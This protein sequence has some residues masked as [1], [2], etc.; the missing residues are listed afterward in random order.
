[1]SEVFFDGEFLNVRLSSRRNYKVVLELAKTS[2]YSEYIQNEGIYVISATRKNARELFNANYSFDKSAEIFIKDLKKINDIKYN[3]QLMFKRELEKNQT[4]KDEL[5]DKLFHFQQEGVS[6]MLEMNSNILLADE[7]GLGK[8]PQASSYLRLKE[9]SL[10][11]LVICPA[12][13]K[14]NWERELEKWANVKSYIINGKTPE[15]L[16]EEF[17]RKYPVFII[18]YDILGSEDKA[19]KTAEENRKKAAKEA[20]EKYRK[21]MLKVHGWCDKLIEYNFKTIIADESQALGE[22]GT[23]RTRAVTQICEALPDAK[24]IMISGT[25]YETRTSQFYPLLHIIRPTE[26]NNKFKFLMRYCDPVKTFFGWQFNGLSNAEELHERICKF[27]IR[28]LKKDVLKDLPPKIRSVIPL[29]ISAS[30]RAMYDKADSELELAVMN[31]E[32]CVLAKMAK[33]KQVAFEAKKNAAIQ[34]IKDYIENVGKLVVFIWHRKSYETL[35]S[36]FGKTAV[37]LVG[38]VSLEDRQKAVDEFQT[39]DKI[40]LFI[41]NIKSAGT[42]ITLTAA[43]ATVFLEF[44]ST[45][46]GHLQAEDRVHRIGQTADSVMAQYLILEN[47]I[48]EDSMTTLNKRAKDLEAV[49]DGTVSSDMFEVED[50]MSMATLKE[51]I[52][53]KNLKNN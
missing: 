51:Y 47:S 8:T 50:D 38:G 11:A 31:K 46:P 5:F 4:K 49:I 6:K 42:G 13:L 23:I 45:A 16:S 24:K 26:F 7:Q 44:G 52:K 34:Y 36:E 41:G 35:M 19:E 32:E 29:Q 10:P 3:G 21:R 9:N 15:N 48:E 33:L 14:L 12:S 30:E 17:L 53:R 40:K 37:G 22:E 25:P 2:S 20:G 43:A 39:N 18:N 28:R 1:M 27:M